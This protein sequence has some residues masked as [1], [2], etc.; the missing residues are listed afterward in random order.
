MFTHFHDILTGSCVQDTREHAM[1]LYQTSMATANTQ[2][3]N[4]MRVIAE[5]IDTSSILV[6]IDAYNTQ[7]EGAGAGYGIENFVGVPSTERGSGKTRIFHV[8]NPLPKARSEAVELTVWDWTGDLREIG[9]KDWKGSD[10]AFQ[11]LDKELRQYWDHKYFRILADV[12]VPAFGY[13]TV[14]LSQQTPDEYRVYFQQNE[15]VSRFMT[16]V[17]CATSIWK[18]CFRPR[19]G[20][21]ARCAMWKRGSN[22]SQMGRRRGLFIWRRKPQPPAPGRLGGRYGKL[23]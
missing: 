9:M 17:C 4:A 14:I 10:V 1:G 13:T 21:C 5:Q 8:F 6:D 7:S 15:R 11:L 3:Q 16:T 19:A 20:A 18:R 23:R 2:I 22:C 12:T